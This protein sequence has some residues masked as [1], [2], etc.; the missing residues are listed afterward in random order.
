MVGERPH[1]EF[2]EVTHR[3]PMLSL[4]NGFNEDDIKDFDARLKRLLGG[5][6]SFQYAVEPKIDGVSVEL[7]YE[8]G[9]LT[10]AS[11]RG[12]G[13]VGEDIT[14]NIKTILSVPLTLLPIVEDMPIPE[15]LEV[16]GDVYMEVQAFEELN[17]ARLSKGL[18]PFAN[19]RNAAAGTL[20]QP[21]NNRQKPPRDVLLRN[22]R[23]E[24]S[25][26]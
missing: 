7:V 21:Q 13:Y 19:P 3:Q 8:R 14:P 17:R 5:G 9:I 4:E 11:T 16:R 26:L 25:D 15:L 6:H 2:R 22:R 1:E 24:G 12:D 10:L 20:R 23:N 18:P